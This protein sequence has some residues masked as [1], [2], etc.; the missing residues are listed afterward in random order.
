[1]SKAI[2]SPQAILIK[3]K[4]SSCI[5]FEKRFLSYRVDKNLNTKA[6]VD[7]VVIGIA[8]LVLSLDELKVV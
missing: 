6:D 8:L 2:L 5:T 4:F 1:M 7:T 3:K